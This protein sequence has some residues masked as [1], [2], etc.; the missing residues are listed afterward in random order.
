[1]VWYCL[2]LFGCVLKELVNVGLMQTEEELSVGREGKL[3]E[4]AGLGWME[5]FEFQLYSYQ[6]KIYIC[7]FLCV[8]LL[9]SKQT[10]A[11]PSS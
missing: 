4:A 7:S 8:A 5:N 10:A 2:G 3:K 11:F 9:S 1:M 6:S